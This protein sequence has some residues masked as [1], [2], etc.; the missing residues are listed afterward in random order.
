MRNRNDCGCGGIP[1]YGLQ[2]VGLGQASSSGPSFD[3]KRD[4]IA[5][6]IAFTLP[7]IYPKVAPKKWYRPGLFGNLVAVIGLYF[8]AAWVYEQV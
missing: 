4:V 2:G 1:N 5:G 7:A 6:A 3:L 8:A